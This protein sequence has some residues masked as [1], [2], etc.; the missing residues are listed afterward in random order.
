ML[1]IVFVYILYITNRNHLSGYFCN[2]LVYPELASFVDSQMLATLQLVF[3]NHKRLVWFQIVVVVCPTSV[4]HMHICICVSYVSPLG[5]DKIM[6]H[7][8]IY[9][10]V[11]TRSIAN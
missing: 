11:D 8:Y 7:R 4:G 3:S 1:I 2:P 9:R 6:L 5:N 10:Y